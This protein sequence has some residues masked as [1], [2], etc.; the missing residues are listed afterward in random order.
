MHIPGATSY[1]KIKNILS[2]KFE[3]TTVNA[4]IMNPNVVEVFGPDTVQYNLTGTVEEVETSGVLITTTTTIKKIIEIYISGF[5]I[6]ISTRAQLTNFLGY[7]EEL[8]KLLV[9]YKG[10]NVKSTIITVPD[11]KINLDQVIKFYLTLVGS[12][13]E[14]IDGM[15]TEQLKEEIEDDFLVVGSSAAFKP[16]LNT[17]S[18]FVNNVLGDKTFND[19]DTK[20]VLIRIDKDGY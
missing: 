5:N 9:Q 8:I 2:C 15:L 6:N 19:T 14:L 18:R 1:E 17:G 3:V 12:N 4:A 7:V 20:N 16:K 11:S 13:K 10:Q